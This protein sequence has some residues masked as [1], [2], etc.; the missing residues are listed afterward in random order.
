MKLLINDRMGTYEKENKRASYKTLVEYFIGDIVLCN[1]IVNIDDSIWDN[2][3][4]EETY[5]NE[6]G[7]E[8]TYDE[9]L[10]DDNAYT[11][12]NDEF[13][14]Y[15]LCNLSE[16]EREKATEAGL[17]LSYSDK[18]ECDVLC[19]T[20]YGTSWSY[21]LTSVELVDSYEELSE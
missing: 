14:Q 19:V 15:Y 20:H 9:Y 18:L 1:N 3:E 21:V 11:E 10:E 5:Y 4:V 6:N 7:E 8:I 2:L 13:Y 17:V 16:Y 12:R